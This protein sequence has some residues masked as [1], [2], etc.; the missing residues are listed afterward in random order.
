MSETLVL[1]ALA[2][3]A[4][5]LY[6]Y[7]RRRDRALSLEAMLMVTV[8]LSAGCAMA[9]PLQPLGPQMVATEASTVMRIDV[10]V[11]TDPGELA[12]WCHQRQERRWWSSA[13]AQ[14][15][16]VLAG[17]LAAAA[18]ARDDDGIEL[19]LELG[20]VGSSALAAGSQAYSGAQASAYE[21]HCRG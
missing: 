3:C 2:A 8:V 7:R 16:G 17:G 18:L 21:Q 1:V 5:V 4:A 14:G 15:F 13:L 9:P 6:A 12:R 19:A 11:V 10:D 20:S